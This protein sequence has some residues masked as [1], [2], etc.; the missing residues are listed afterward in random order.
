MIYSEEKS[1]KKNC[2]IQEIKDGVGQE[3][4]INQKNQMGPQEPADIVHSALQD[5]SKQQC[6]QVN[7]KMN[8][9]QG[10]RGQQ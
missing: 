9:S 10:N 4:I 7:N 3:Q 5:E 2:V 8:S 6:I 1:V